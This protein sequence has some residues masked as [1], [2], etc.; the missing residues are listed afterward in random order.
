MKISY[1]KRKKN[2]AKLTKLAKKK[3]S[4]S[5][6]EIRSISLVSNVLQYHAEGLNKNLV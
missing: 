3:K 6:N 5:I 2:Y 1:T 4:I